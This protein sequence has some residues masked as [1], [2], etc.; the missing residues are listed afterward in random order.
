MLLNSSPKRAVTGFDRTAVTIDRDK[1]QATYPR[2]NAGT[3]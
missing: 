2:G 3:W 1:R